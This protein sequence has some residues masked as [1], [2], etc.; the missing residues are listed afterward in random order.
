MIHE[1]MKFLNFKIPITTSLLSRGMLYLR[2]FSFLWVSWMP[3]THAKAWLERLFEEKLTCE[4]LNRGTEGKQYWIFKLSSMSSNSYPSM[5]I[6]YSI[7]KDN[8]VATRDGN[9]AGQGWVRSGL[10]QRPFFGARKIY[11][12]EWGKSEVGRCREV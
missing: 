1:D 7:V 8:V 3:L 5:L 4:N 10:S 2:H 12:W 9:W 6:F 11:A